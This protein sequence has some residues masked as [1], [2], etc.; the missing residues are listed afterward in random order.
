MANV[1]LYR[2]SFFSRL[3]ILPTHVYF[4]L[5]LKSQHYYLHNMSYHVYCY[6][7]YAGTTS[8]RIAYSCASFTRI[9]SAYMVRFVSRI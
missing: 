7:I 8:F 5:S 3:N 6:Q 1:K 4:D 9:V 2:T